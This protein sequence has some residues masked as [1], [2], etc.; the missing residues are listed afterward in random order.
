MKKGFSISLSILMLAAT[1][2]LSFATHYCGGQEIAM[3]V[4]L[5]GKLAECGKTDCGMDGSEKEIPPPGTNL[6][7]H[8]CDDVVTFYGISSN[9]SSTYSFIPESYKY[10]FQVLAIP[11]EFSAKSQT[12]NNSLYSNV[13]PPGALMSTNVD[14]SSI[15]VFRI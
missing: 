5:T 9:Y 12:Y 2:H 7:K 3:K 15:C 4:S 10:N 8:C 13:S 14:L 1:L 6:T 11:V